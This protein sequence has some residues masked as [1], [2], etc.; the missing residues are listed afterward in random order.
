MVKLGSYCMFLLLIIIHKTIMANSYNEG[1]VLAESGLNDLSNLAKDSS[2]KNEIPHYNDN[3]LESN[4]SEQQ[5][6]QKTEEIKQDKDNTYNYIKKI[7]KNKDQ[8]LTNDSK[9]QE[10]KWFKDS[11]EVSR[12]AKNIILKDCKAQRGLNKHLSNSEPQTEIYKIKVEGVKTITEVKTCEET[13]L[14]EKLCIRELQ[15]NCVDKVECDVDKIAPTSIASDMKWEHQGNYITLSTLSENWRSASQDY[16]N[17]DNW[18]NFCK[19]YDRVTTFNIADLNKIRE[20]KLVEEWADDYLQVK[21]NDQI[22]FSNLDGDK[23]E[24]RDMTVLTRLKAVHNGIKEFLCER[25]DYPNENNYY[26]NKEIDLKPYL[27][28]G[29]NEI[30]MRTIIGAQG[31]AWIK[32][33]AKQDCCVKWSESWK[34]NCG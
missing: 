29:Q 23:L 21:I 9:F 30:F 28:E 4:L 8:S 11:L 15:L 3:P 33:K 20:F 22:V 16:W 10:E 24:V 19:E 14:V 27:K 25:N 18:F 26:F 31:K 6:R 13:T 2:L 1:K 34:E 5:L 7:K 32:I 17:D 12:N